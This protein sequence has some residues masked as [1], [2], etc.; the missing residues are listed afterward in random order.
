MQ[1]K[2]Q[3]LLALLGVF[4]KRLSLSEALP[5]AQA[6]LDDPR[7]RAQ[8]QALCYGVL[9]Q[10][11]RLEKISHSL[12]KKPFR[13]KDLDIQ[14]ILELSLHQ[15]FE[16][17]AEHAVVDNANKL[18][19]WRKKIWAKGVVNAVLR[20]AIRQ[21]R[22]A[23]TPRNDIERFSHPQW[24]VNF[25]R[26]NWIEQAD[27]ILHANNT[28]PPLSLRINVHKQ[29]QYF[30]QHGEHPL[31]QGQKSNDSRLCAWTLDTPCDVRQ[32]PEFELGTLSVQDVAA[33]WAGILLNPQN[34]ERILDACAAPGGKTG[35]LLELAPAAHVTALDISE[36]RLARVEENMQRLGLSDSITLL[37]GDLTQYH[38]WWDGH[39]FDKILLD[40]P[41]SALG[42]IRRNPDI[43]YLRQAEDIAPLVKLQAQCLD[44]C[45]QMLKPNGHLLYATCS[46]AKAENQYQVQRFLE[47]NPN[48][49]L[50]ETP[51]PN[52]IATGHGQQF[53]PNNADNTDG[54]FYALLLKS[55]TAPV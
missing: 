1:S 10:H 20:Q 2:Q 53:L 25:I 5:K 3:A 9:R 4:G 33:Q 44:A 41:C 13:N 18:V 26:G 48:A 29:A 14:L 55:T 31:L 42:V 43:K 16:G 17:A 45:W 54:F 49:E 38:D 7:H 32:L 24:L 51:L 22:L 27:D 52:T 28:H 40:A 23:Q 8:C 19:K 15:L 47:Q 12:L 11:H 36:T 37:R 35:H 6:S 50:L 30:E 34:G 21:G 39:T 46:I